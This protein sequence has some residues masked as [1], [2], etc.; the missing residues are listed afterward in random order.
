[1]N[2]EREFADFLNKKGF[3]RFYLAWI[4]KY[5]KMGYLG[6]TI[7]LSHLNNYEKSCL[8]GLLGI[9]LTRGE[10]SLSFQ[11][12]S[13]ILEKTYFEGAD[14]L[15][16]LEYLHGEKIITNKEA[17]DSYGK[18]L[19]LFKDALLDMYINTPSYKW[20]KN[21]FD[22]D[23]YVKK[24]Y[25]ENKNHYRD[26]L[27]NVC[28][29]L[30]QLPIYKDEYQLLA[31]F[32]QSITKDPHYFD[33]DLP[34]ELL[35]KGII[36]ILEIISPSSNEIL[37]NAGILKDD[38]S[39]Y[40]YICHINPINHEAYTYFYENYEPFNINL[41]NLNKIDELFLTSKILIIEN[42]SVFRELSQF[43]KEKK[44][45]IGL[46]CSNGQINLCT[47]QL[48]DKLLKS[49]CILFY[50]GDFDPEGLQIADK[51]KQKYGD[52]IELWQYTKLNFEKSKI[53]QPII[54]QRR[55]TILENI[56][57]IHLKNIANIIKSTS[58]FV[59]QEGL[60]EIYKKEIEKI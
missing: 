21:Y 10:L 9:D 15:K 18:Q 56:Q 41:Y 31:V 47:Y 16:T 36:E 2:K 14:F 26:I 3:T 44:L 19:S 4:E 49:R 30:N 39:N 55:L 34:R 57:D 25:N 33:D 35:I 54:S 58:C 32:S 48:L 45:N 22:T 13:K 6:G 38:L 7:K 53:Y 17:K 46:I 11:K 20:L 51:L 8:G 27:S 42:P 29:A 52:K 59:Y 24:Y 43:I 12:L 1:M 40:C 50:C 5:K 60:I 37:Y 28:C 23:K